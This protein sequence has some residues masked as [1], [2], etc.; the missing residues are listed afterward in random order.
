MLSAIQLFP[1]TGTKSTWYVVVVVVV[2]A[3]VV[4]VIAVVAVAVAVDVVVVVVVVVDVF[5]VVVVAVVV[6]AVAVAFFHRQLGFSSEPEGKKPNLKPETG[7]LLRNCF[8]YG[9]N[10]PSEG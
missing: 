6:V 2:A 1:S 8:I 7:Q 4:I 10:L 3:V 9:Q 5:V